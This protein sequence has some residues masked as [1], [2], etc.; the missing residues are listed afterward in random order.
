M[1]APQI[2][3]QPIGIAQEKIAGLDLTFDD[4]RDLR[5]HAGGGD[6]DLRQGLRARRARRLGA[7]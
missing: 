6:L 3:D 2:H 4:H 5:L 1:G 7:G